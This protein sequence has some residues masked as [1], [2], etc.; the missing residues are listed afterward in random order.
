MKAIESR[1]HGRWFKQVKFSQTADF[2]ENDSLV[3]SGIA[4]LLYF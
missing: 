2:Y 4:L 3:K 1:Y